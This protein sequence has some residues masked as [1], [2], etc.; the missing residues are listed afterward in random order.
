MN[1]TLQV[2]QAGEHF[3]LCQGAD[4]LCEVCPNRGELGDCT[5]G[6]DNALERDSAAF[7]VLHF[8]PGESITW[9]A[10]LQKL[11]QLR[12]REFQAVCSG[13]RWQN[14]GLCSLALLQKQAKQ[15]LEQTN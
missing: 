3:Q 7:S 1:A 10:A 2:L 15:Y 5:L 6:T 12:E 4:H 9:Q 13:C 14:E 11:L 8:Q